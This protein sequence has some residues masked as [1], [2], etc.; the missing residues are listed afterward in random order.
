MR[1]LSERGRLRSTRSLASGGRGQARRHLAQREAARP[2]NRG[3]L[4]ELVQSARGIFGDTRS[5]P[6][7]LSNGSSMPSGRVE[8]KIMLAGHFRTCHACSAR[9]IVG[10]AD[11]A[12]GG[13]SAQWVVAVEEVDGKWIERWRLRT[14]IRD[15]RGKGKPDTAIPFDHSSSLTFKLIFPPSRSPGIPCGR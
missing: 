1:P 15:G 3:S 7:D 10:K 4:L 9:L 13:V 12:T 8:V 5:Q 2:P 11:A 14:G 6:T